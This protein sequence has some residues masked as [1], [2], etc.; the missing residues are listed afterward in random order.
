MAGLLPPWGTPA[1]E[2]ARAAL[3]SALLLLLF[4]A[5]ELW[6]RRWDPPTEW[7]RK[8]VHF[9][10]G[11]VAAGFPWLFAR[12]WTVLALGIAFAAIIWGT[13]R[14][15]LLQG[16]HGVQRRSQG[17]IYYPVAI[18]L[19]FLLAA[20]R[21]V[22]Y[23]ISL[24]V[25]MVSDTL[26][27]LL[28]TEYGRQFYAVETDR[29]SLEGSAA[30]FLTTF[31]AV[32]LPLLLLTDVG[33]GASVLVAAQVALTV[34]IFEGISLEGSDN[35]IAPLATYGLLAAMT[36][37]PAG[38]VARQLAA[39]LLI[40]VLVGLLAW[41]FR[42]LAMSSAMG[43]ALVVYGAYALGGSEWT[44]AP[45]L[46]VL[47]FAGFHAVVRR[48]A[49]DAPSRYHIRG[50]FYVALVPIL[51]FALNN[52]LERF[53][54][55]ALRPAAPDPL[56]VPFV[57]VVAAQLVIVSFAH[58]MAVRPRRRRAALSLA[59]SGVFLGF[60]AVV[61][62]ALAVGAAGLTLTG[63]LAA[64]A[65]CGVA[66]ALYLSVRR[67]PVWPGVSPWDLRLQSLSAGVAMAMVLPL[68]LWHIGAY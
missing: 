64:G 5:A 21:P 11:V 41:R 52:A 8:L 33:R 26:A 67:L 13:R 30:F 22:F 7:T 34:T 62:A 31:L 16:I 1:A 38:F 65:I 3:V 55:P 18:Y 20:D 58:V 35:L 17:G 49:P 45:A 12:H 63:L 40:T 37:Q 39:Q 42:F 2:T 27:A 68:H 61:P 24:L 53:A 44:L 19:V 51:L 32:H 25:L 9:G 15:G 36:P 48:V 50:L 6:K 56:Y 54:G 4:A 47:W 14:M 43:L 59:T 66:L 10:G 60:L 23:L 29:R 57:G 28:G 46:A